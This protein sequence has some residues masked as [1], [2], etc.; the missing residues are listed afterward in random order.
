MIRITDW[1]LGDDET[2]VCLADLRKD[3][4]VWIILYLE[5]RDAYLTA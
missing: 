3:D 1:S 5:C 2:E 4:F